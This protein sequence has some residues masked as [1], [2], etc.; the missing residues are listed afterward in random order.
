MH[1]D[2]GRVSLTTSSLVGGSERVD[3]PESAPA[4]VARGRKS[5]RFPYLVMATF[6]AEA[7]AMQAL[8]CRSPMRRAT[9]R[10]WG[11]GLVRHER[12]AP[13]L[14]TKEVLSP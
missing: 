7:F 11:R 12:R 5:F 4:E 3:S 13:A 6:L 9:A 10:E 14:E 1:G 8:S 2:V